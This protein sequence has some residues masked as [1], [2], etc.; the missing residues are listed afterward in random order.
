MVNE[1]SKAKVCSPMQHSLQRVFKYCKLT[2]CVCIQILAVFLQFIA[3]YNLQIDK[4]DEK[5]FT[6]LAYVASGDV[7]PMQA[8]IGSITAHEVIKVSTYL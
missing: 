2:L 4:I 6:W 7:A 8:V 1:G 5:L 3:T